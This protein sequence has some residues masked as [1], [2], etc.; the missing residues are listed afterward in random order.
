M[1]KPNAGMTPKFD[2]GKKMI[3]T[4]IQKI[5]IQ[6]TRLLH[7]GNIEAA[8]DISNMADAYE[9]LAAEYGRIM[10]MAG[11]SESSEAAAND[12]LAWVEP[13]KRPAIE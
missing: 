10:E 6:A 4:G 7:S 11:F 2:K 8:Q 9:Y 3:F 5:R 13:T 1:K 12:A